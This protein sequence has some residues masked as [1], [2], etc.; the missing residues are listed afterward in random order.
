MNKFFMILAMCRRF[1]KMGA[2]EFAYEN[3]NG[4]ITLWVFYP[5][6]NGWGSEIK[7][8]VVFETF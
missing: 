3:V 2:N 4:K 1:K 5:S 7:E 8:M 6:V